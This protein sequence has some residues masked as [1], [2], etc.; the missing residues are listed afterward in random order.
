MSVK[1]DSRIVERVRA[2]RRKIVEECGYDL[3][4]LFE[5]MRKAEKVSGRK[6]KGP[7]DARLRSKTLSR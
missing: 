1:S 7:R 2:V 4:S 3:H 5:R 6:A